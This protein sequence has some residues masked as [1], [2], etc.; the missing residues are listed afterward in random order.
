V[1]S[2][3]KSGSLNLLEPLGPVQVCTRMDLPSHTTQYMKKAAMINCVKPQHSD[4]E[5]MT[6]TSFRS[7][8]GRIGGQSVKLR[9]DR[10]FLVRYILVFAEV[11][12]VY[13]LI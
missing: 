3:R 13:R 4:E 6:D 2:F 8:Y 5:V 9:Y 12:P 11:S 1:P 7:N 10:C